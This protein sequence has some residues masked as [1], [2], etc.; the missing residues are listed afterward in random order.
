MRPSADAGRC[1]GG[2]QPAAGARRADAG[3]PV[4]RSVRPSQL[5]RETPEEPA[6]AGAGNTGRRD[7]VVKISLSQ[8][9]AHAVWAAA[10]GSGWRPGAW[11]G[12]V[13]EVALLGGPPPPM[14]RPWVAAWTA[15]ETALGLLRWVAEAV[16][17]GPPPLQQ[18]PG[19]GA[20]SA[21]VSAEEMFDSWVAAWV[22]LGDPRDGRAGEEA[23]ARA[24]AAELVA[25]REELLRGGRSAQAAAAERA[26]L[27]QLEVAHAASTRRALLTK[28]FLAIGGIGG[29]DAAASAPPTPSLRAAAGAQRAAAR[30]ALAAALAGSAA[31]ARRREAQED[32]GVWAGRA[33]AVAVLEA[34]RRQG[35]RAARRGKG[36]GRVRANVRLSPVGSEA[37]DLVLSD[38]G[39]TRADWLATVGVVAAQA[40]AG[41]NELRRRTEEVRA[42]AVLVRDAAVAL[43]AEASS[44]AGAGADALDAAQRTAAG[45]EVQRVLKDI[46]EDGGGVG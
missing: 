9:E 11:V 6:G 45:G 7:V 26:A 37:L 10:E 39:W 13:I 28:E 36:A 8:G 46:D 21:R 33:A 41:S 32:A 4:T 16:A 20:V 3:G 22:P 30:A 40:A 23:A 14:F 12:A 25:Q 29:R 35:A 42:A 15:L 34:E 17:A 1:G 38:G 2:F 43:H 18:G 31:A 44:P 5:W 27:R 24:R 19:R